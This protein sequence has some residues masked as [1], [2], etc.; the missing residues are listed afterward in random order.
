M[1]R[2]GMLWLAVLGWTLGPAYGQYENE[3]EVFRGGGAYLGVRIRDLNEVDVG[4]LQLGREAGVFVEGVEKGSPADEAGLQKGDIIWEY[5]GSPV[6]SVRQLR[7]LVAETPMGRRVELTLR[8]GDEKLKT[9]A[10]IGRRRHCLPPL[11]REFRK[12]ELRFPTSWR[13]I[14]GFSS[15]QTAPVF[16]LPPGSSRNKWQIFSELRKGRE[17]WSWRWSRGVLLMR[18]DSKRAT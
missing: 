17:F 5:A 14:A 7:R 2:Q 8:R 16:G 6:I 3:I 1:V 10:R 15:F 12:P 13:D 9:T 18:Q 4:K 11:T